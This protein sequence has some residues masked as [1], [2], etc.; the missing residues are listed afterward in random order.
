MVLGHDGHLRSPASASGLERASGNRCATHSCRGG[1]IPL[2]GPVATSLAA[3]RAYRSPPSGSHPLAKAGRPAATPEITPGLK[4]KQDADQE[5]ARF[6]FDLSESG[7]SSLDVVAGPA[8]KQAAKRA[9]QVT[10]EA[11]TT[12]SV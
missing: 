8:T 9:T 11:C 6:C 4:Q 5:Q 12:F 7:S 1:N 2:R 10:L 3:V